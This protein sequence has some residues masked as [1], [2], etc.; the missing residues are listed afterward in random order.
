MFAAATLPLGERDRRL[1]TL[2]ERL[3]GGVFDAVAGCVACGE[4][5]ELGFTA[6]DLLSSVPPVTPEALIEHARD[7]SFDF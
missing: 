7:N 2:R 5:M 6:A 4:S 1:F 3:S